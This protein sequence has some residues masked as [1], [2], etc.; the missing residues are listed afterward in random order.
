MSGEK[1]EAYINLLQSLIQEKIIDQ[2]SDLFA[3][4]NRVIEQVKAEME[5]TNG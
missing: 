3:N 2:D 1:A 4:V 5:A